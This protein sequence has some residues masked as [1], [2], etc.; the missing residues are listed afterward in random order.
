MCVLK[1]QLLLGICHIITNPTLSL[2]KGSLE[3]IVCQFRM[4]DLQQLIDSLAGRCLS[5]VP[6]KLLDVPYFEIYISHTI[7]N[8]LFLVDSN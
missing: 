3:V 5:P 2:I 8:R 4:E 1:Y 6:L 7:Y